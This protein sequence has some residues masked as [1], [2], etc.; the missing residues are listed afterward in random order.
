MLK[1]PP[2]FAL[3]PR[4]DMKMVEM[5]VE[6]GIWKARWEDRSEEQRGRREE[7]TEQEM[8]EMMAETRV[9]DS[10]TK[11][12][13]YS[14]IRVTQLPTNRR[15]VA[16]KPL[17][18]SGRNKEVQ[19]QFLKARL[20]DETKKHLKKEY[21]EHGRPK[22]SNITPEEAKGLRTA[23]DITEDGTVIIR[24]TDKTSKHSIDSSANYARKMEEHIK[25]DHVITEKEKE[26][27]VR[28]CNGH[29]AFWRRM[30]NLGE[31]HPV[32]DALGDRMT[33][34]I[35]Q[36]QNMLPPPMVGNPKD[37]KIGAEP[38]LRPICQAKS[39]PNNILS[40]ILAKLVGKVGEE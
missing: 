37:H 2:K 24:P 21:D 10:N 1:L 19:L 18:G 36:D 31:A 39:A 4:V 29:A 28:E 17:T 6:R 25:D 40:W 16:P 13:N 32:N 38:P 8:E 30:I 12:L 34:A 11:E 35:T 5:E 27:S 15:V 9:W 20:L 22:E 7:P 14:K 33:S 26:R 23:R 3:Y